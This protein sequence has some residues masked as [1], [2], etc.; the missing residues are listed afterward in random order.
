MSPEREADCLFCKIID[1]KIPAKI[2]HEDEKSL[3]F[4]DINPQAP[5][6]LLI[7]PKRH[8]IG[9]STLQPGETE[10]VAHLFSVVPKLAREKGISESGFRTVVNSGREAGQTV[11]HLHV[12][13]LGGRPFQWPP[14]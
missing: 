5:V 11:F 6:H 14:G 13:L 12:H 2:V 8:I 1:K 10:Q 4:Q 7:I 9:L 3:A